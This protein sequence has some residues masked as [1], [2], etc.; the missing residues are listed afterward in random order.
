MRPTF[1]RF[2]LV[3][4]T[5]TAAAGIAVVARGASSFGATS[6]DRYKTHVIAAGA[7]TQSVAANGTINPVTL[8]SVGTQVSGTVKRLYVDF[9]SK[10][11]KGQPLLELDDALY[12]AQARQS[13]AA[14]ESASVALELAGVNE[15]RLEALN[16]QGFVSRQEFEQAQYARRAAAA[17]LALSKAAKEKDAV[18]LGYTVIRSPVSGVVVDRVVDVG[19][20]VAA[21]FQTPTLIRI[22]Q[23]LSKMQ[24]DASFAEADIG[25]IKLDQ[26]ARFNVDAFPNKSFTG[27][28][29]QLRLNPTTVQNVVTY[30]VVVAVENSDQLLLPG[31]TAYV[32]IAVASKEG[33]LQVPNGALRYKP[34][35][36]DDAKAGKAEEKKGKK[37]G[38][39]GTVY[40]LS[41]ETTRAVPVALGISDNRMTEIASGELKAGDVVIGGEKTAVEGAPAGSA[42]PMRVRLF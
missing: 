36:S 22:A 13:A 21:S 12:A 26:I 18:N 4:A 3:A 10:V 24:I 28:V 42:S 38:A 25:L 17:Q 20:T 8:V 32:S 7:L 31:M 35:R 23:D 14:F 41:Q 11:E 16:A 37:G 30:D 15:R 19:Q 39:T 9:N 5:V 33:V 40:L 27:K 29:M 34:A 2:A 6:A 1:K